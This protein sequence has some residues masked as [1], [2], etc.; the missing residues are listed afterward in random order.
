MS[1]RAIFFDLDGTLVHS[2]PDIAQAANLAL[3]SVGQQ[4]RAATEV[5][6]YIGH[7]A[8]QLIHRCL[9][10]DL[11]QRA[12]DQLHQATYRH[13]QSHYAACLLDQTRPYPGVIETLETL[14]QRG[15]ALGCI[16]N[17][18]ERFTFP[19]LDGLGLARFF[20][21]T[22]GGDSLPTKKPDPAPLLHAARQCGTDPSTTAMVGDSLADL[23]AAR[24]AKM[25]IYCVDYGYRG[26]ADLAAHAP[27]AL[28]S[29]MR[30]L[31]PLVLN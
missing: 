23:H 18:P 11:H 30:Q 22:L 3:A 2:A 10:G 28:I 15:V 14:Q 7:G 21:I 29:D 27:D 31:L 16:T 24:A 13:F 1:P 20:K 5:E 4:P 12:D 8:E 25:R 17:K 19:L 6:A 26:D 9:T